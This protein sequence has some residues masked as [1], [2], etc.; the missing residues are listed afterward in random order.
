MTERKSLRECIQC[1]I[2][3]AEADE[4]LKQFRECDDKIRKHIDDDHEENLK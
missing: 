4:Y 2:W 3:R 1:Q